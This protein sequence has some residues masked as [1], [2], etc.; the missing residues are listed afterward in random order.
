MSSL[1]GILVMLQWCGGPKRD[2]VRDVWRRAE[3][4]LRTTVEA[5]KSVVLVQYVVKSSI[6]SVVTKHDVAKGSTASTYTVALGVELM[7]S[8]VQ[9][10]FECGDGHET[11]TT[12]PEKHNPT[13]PG[14]RALCQ[15]HPCLSRRVRKRFSQPL[16]SDKGASHHCGAWSRLTPHHS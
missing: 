4:V 7:R 11:S 16:S 2:V 3:Q 1:Y 8:V 9:N 6:A 10:T 5:P 15:N 12:S 14:R 13:F